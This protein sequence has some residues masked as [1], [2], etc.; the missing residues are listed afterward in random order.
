MFCLK[1]CENDLLAMY[2]AQLKKIKAMVEH[3]SQSHET[4]AAC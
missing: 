3:A 4:T 2:V 1:I